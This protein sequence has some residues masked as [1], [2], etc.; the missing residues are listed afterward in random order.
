MIK[1]DQKIVAEKLLQRMFRQKV[2]F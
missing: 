1:F 2:Y